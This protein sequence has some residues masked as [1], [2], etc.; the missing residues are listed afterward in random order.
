[1][2]SRYLMLMTAVPVCYFAG[3]AYREYYDPDQ[4]MTTL[5]RKPETLS[6]TLIDSRL[7]T[8]EDSKQ[9]VMQQLSELESH[10]EKLKNTAGRDTDLPGRLW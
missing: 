1:M 8:L 10:R 4:S 6:D 3:Y 2:S 9:K 7:K 5:H